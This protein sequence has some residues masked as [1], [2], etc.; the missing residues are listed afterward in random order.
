MPRRQILRYH[1]RRRVANVNCGILRRRGGG[2]W[3]LWGH[4]GP[5]QV[6]SMGIKQGGRILSYLP[7]QQPAWRL[8]Q[9]VNKHSDGATLEGQFQSLLILINCGHW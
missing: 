8:N 3:G 2:L 6:I 1:Q 9:I 7:S 4:Q 5:H